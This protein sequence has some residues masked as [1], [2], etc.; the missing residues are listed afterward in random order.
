[1]TL[2]PG[3]QLCAPE[4]HSWSHHHGDLTLCGQWR[5]AGK[6]AQLRGQSWDRTAELWEV[7]LSG[8]EAQYRPLPP[9]TRTRR[10]SGSQASLRIAWNP[11]SSSL[12]GPSLGT[13]CP[14]PPAV[15]FLSSLRSHTECGKSPEPR[16]KR[17]HGPGPRRPPAFAPHPTPGSLPLT[18]PTL[19]WSWSTPLDLPGISQGPLWSRLNPPMAEDRLWACPQ[20]C[21]F[22][23]GG[24][25][26]ATSWGL[27][28]SIWKL[29]R[30]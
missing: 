18:L 7:G 13:T 14:H 1:M 27:S 12:S 10:V 5:N 22:P 6:V 11:S 23:L 4:G 16:G 20:P 29:V 9:S 17:R 24:P 15:P 28:V 19:S 2:V 26:P 8:R 3:L 21:S 30:R 25:G